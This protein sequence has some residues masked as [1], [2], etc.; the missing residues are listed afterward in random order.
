MSLKLSILLT[1]WALSLGLGGCGA[2][3]WTAEGA[4]ARQLGLLDGDLDGRVSSA[5]YRAHRYTGPPF[6]TADQDG[7]GALSAPEL[8]RLGRGQDGLRF[9]GAV[10]RPTYPA[11]SVEAAGLSA[12]QMAV[13][14][15]LGWM[16]AS[17]AAGGAA[18]L[19][20]AALRAAV[21]SG[22]LESAASIACLAEMKPR[23]TALGRPWPAGLPAVP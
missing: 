16:S 14:E 22:E 4:A 10:A 5:E 23:W 20:S 13:L 19:D 1:G 18:P 3:R 12:P 9:D 21:D 11:H 8:L 15:V 17:L 2:P 6:G 7:D